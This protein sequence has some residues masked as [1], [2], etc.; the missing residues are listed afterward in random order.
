MAAHFLP[1]F[2]CGIDIDRV[3]LDAVTVSANAL[4]RE[5]GRPAPE[6]GVKDD[7]TAFG[8]VQKGI[9][10]QRDRLCGGMQLECA[11]AAFA[12][13]AVGAGIIPD[14]GAIAPETAELDIVEMPVLTVSKH[15]HEFMS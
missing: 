12:G 6:I 9:G 15:E 4:R 10:N 2:D 13:K 11:F 14:I 1:T 8:R 7:V 3:D 5:D